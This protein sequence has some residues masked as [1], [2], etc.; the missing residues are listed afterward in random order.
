MSCKSTSYA[1]CTESLH[2]TW[3]RASLGSWTGGL[4]AKSCIS[5]ILYLRRPVASSTRLKLPGRLTEENLLR[6]RLSVEAVRAY[7]TDQLSTETAPR[8]DVLPSIERIFGLAAPEPAIPHGSTTRSIRFVLSRIRRTSLDV[9]GGFCKTAIL[10]C[11]AQSK[12]SGDLA[13]N[14]ALRLENLTAR[15]NRHTA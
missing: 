1:R 8:Q 13:L 6:V 2:R 12:G 15:K 3:C 10:R 11:S 4:P 7:L 5:C 14:D 9:R